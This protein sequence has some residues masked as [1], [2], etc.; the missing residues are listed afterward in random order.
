MP[1]EHAIFS[2]ASEFLAREF[3][4]Q[5]I[6]RDASES[7]HAKAATALPFKPAIVIE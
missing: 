6:V 4:V 7:L 3:S 5:V 2:E 1:N